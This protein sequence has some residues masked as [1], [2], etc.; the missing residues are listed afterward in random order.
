MMNPS[1]HGRRPSLEARAHA[2]RPEVPGPE[3]MDRPSP[4]RTVTRDAIHHA[5]S[6]KACAF[7]AHGSRF[8]IEWGCSPGSPQKKCHTVLAFSARNSLKTNNPCT[9]E[10]SHFFNLSMRAKPSRAAAPF[11]DKPINS[12]LA[13][14]RANENRDERDR[15]PGNSQPRSPS[16]PFISKNFPQ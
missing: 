1:V 11:V 6:E 4:G 7:Q 2:T 12:R 8:A 9:K 16:W 3:C 13:S 15:D 5:H 14:A 10:P